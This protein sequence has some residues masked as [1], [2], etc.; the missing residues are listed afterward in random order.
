MALFGRHVVTQIGVPGGPGISLTDLRVRFNIKMSRTSTPDEAVITMYGVSRQ[1]VSILR[2]EGVIISIFAGY[3]VPLQIFTGTPIADGVS[4]EKAG[5]ERVLTIEAQDS[6]KLLKETTL[7]ISYAT[8][9]SAQQLVNEAV[10]ALQLPPGVV[11]VDPSVIFT[12]GISFTGTAKDLLTQMSVACAADWWVRDGVMYFLP[13]DTE[14]G[15]M[16]VEFSSLRGNLIGSPVRKADDKVE[17]IALMEPSMRPGKPF[18]VV[19]EEVNGDFIAQ[20]V[21]FVGDSGWENEFYVKAIG[22]P[23]MAA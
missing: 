19:S 4:L 3:S 5:P 15:E 13:A 22:K 1:T 18:R 21:E 14:T 16:A 11:T 20:D 12:Q 17:I 7:S 10:A 23:R 8:P 2:A 9:V 6:G